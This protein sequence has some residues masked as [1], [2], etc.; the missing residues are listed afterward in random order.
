[1][2]AKLFRKYF[3]NWNLDD[4]I[5]DIASTQYAG[6]H[7]FYRNLDDLNK[8]RVKEGAIAM[9]T[10]SGFWVKKEDHF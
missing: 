4:E 9:Q 8:A 7:V 6:D 2:S 10:A 3:G 5:N 1:M